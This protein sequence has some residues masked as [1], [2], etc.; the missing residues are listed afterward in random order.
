MFGLFRKKKV[1]PLGDELHFKS[2]QAA[3]EYCCRF[4]DT[5]IRD[6]DTLPA[7]V[8]DVKHRQDGRQICAL[9]VAS[10]EGGF[11]LEFCETINEHVPPLRVGDLVAWY[12]AEYSEA[13]G[14][15]GLFMSSWVVEK[16]EPVYNIKHAAW[17]ISRQ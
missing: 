1:P 10:K 11:R 2:N 4:L 5:T 3:F 12:V 16:L 6:R 9:Q 14:K 8:T 13:L 7:L 17:K 15:A